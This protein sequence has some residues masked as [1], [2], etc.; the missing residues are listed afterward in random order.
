MFKKQLLAIIGAAK[1]T[2]PRS[3]LTK[4]SMLIT[5]ILGLI[6]GS[7]VMTRALAQGG[8]RGA[9]TGT[10]KDPGGAAIPNARVEIINQQ[11]SATERI[12]TT[13]S[14]GSFSATLLPVAIY[15]VVVTAAGFTKAEADN[16]KVN[17]T[18]TTNIT[19]SMKI[20]VV[21]ETMSVSGTATTIQ[22][23]S[24]ATGET[25]Q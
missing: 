14:D 13:N 25:I 15:R 16:V 21:T 11:T 7:P 17:V 5:L 4:R 1:K 24:P 3:Q 6:L 19:I 22:T 8:N 18:E 2:R 9:I 12:V 20:G 10:I 23:S